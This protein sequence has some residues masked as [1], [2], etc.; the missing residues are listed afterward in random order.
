VLSATLDSN[1]YISALNFGG[2][3]LQVLNLARGGFIRLDVSD[4]ILEEFAGVL[5]DKF[6]WR[7]DDIADAQQEIRSFANITVYT[8]SRQ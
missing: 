6:R 5:C 8:L 4:A 1:T 3:P 7:E 2:T